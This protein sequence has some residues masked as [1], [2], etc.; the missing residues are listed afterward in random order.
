MR[1][2]KVREGVSAPGVTFSM[3]WIIALILVPIFVLLLVSLVVAMMQ[4][5]KME[6]RRQSKRAP[7]V[8]TTG[9][10]EFVKIGPLWTTNI[11]R[12]ERD[13][14]IFVKDVKG[15]PEPG[16]IAT[17]PPIVEHLDALESQAR[18]AIRELEPHKRLVAICLLDVQGEDFSL[19]FDDIEIPKG[20]SLTDTE[21][22]DAVDG[23]LATLAE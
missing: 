19:N 20:R 23:F 3:N 9:F 11:W 2:C 12:Q 22:K 10:G 21:M 5:A 4:V 13:V 14:S 17:L 8:E 16:H 15:K 6:G 7:I 18:Q 1:D